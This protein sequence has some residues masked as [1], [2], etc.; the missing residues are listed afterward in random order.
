MV[1]GFQYFIRLILYINVSGFWTL[2]E[3]TED[4]LDMRGRSV[5][6]DAGC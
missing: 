6:I 5:M 1:N 4:G 2:E 3:R